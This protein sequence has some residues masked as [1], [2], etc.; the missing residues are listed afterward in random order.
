MTTAYGYEDERW[1]PIVGCSPIGEGCHN[2]WARKFT[3]RHAA[4]PKAP[5]EYRDVCKWDG[6]TRLVESV[7]DKPLHWRKPRRIAV[8]FMGDWCHQSVTPAMRGRVLDIMQDAEWHTFLTLT[9]RPCNLPRSLPRNVWAGISVENQ[10]ALVL[11]WAHLSRVS[12]EVRWLSVEPMLGPI[13]LSGFA[14]LPDWV[15]CGPETGP[16]AR[17][18]DQE[19]M[20]NLARQCAVLGVLFWDKTGTMRQELS[21]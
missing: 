17:P 3:A 14:T 10:G 11:R 5:P 12:A 9:K 2:C 16:S 15:V 1:N 13:D 7:L 6:T 21:R 4:N 20:Q 18:C 19:W 8:S